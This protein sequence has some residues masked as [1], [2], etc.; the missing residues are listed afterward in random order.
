MKPP[1]PVRAWVSRLLSWRFLKFGTIGASGTVVNQVLLYL[2][3]EWLFRAIAQP[4]T[5]LDCSLSLAIL[6]A[7]INNFSW[8]RVWTW[9]DRPRRPGSPLIA[10]FGQYALACW[11]GIV[12]QFVLTKLLV[13]YLNYL[14]ANLIAIVCA[15]VCNFIVNDVWTFRHRRALLALPLAR[16]DGDG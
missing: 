14:I 9:R 3:Q 1:A 5:R 11:V 12:L 10:Q 6:V 8:N 15:S 7:T 13:L 2:G 4:K 16:P